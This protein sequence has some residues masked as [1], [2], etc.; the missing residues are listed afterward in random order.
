MATGDESVDVVDGSARGADPMPSTAEI[1]RLV[2]ALLVRRTAGSGLVL[3]APPEAPSTLAALFS[4]MAQLL[5][6]AGTHA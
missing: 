3:E 1:R 5:Q 2:S 6:S 4:G